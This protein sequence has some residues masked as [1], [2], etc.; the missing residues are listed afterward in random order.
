ME[1]TD[2]GQDAVSSFHSQQ[3]LIM[4][5]RDTRSKTPTPSMDR[6]VA[7]GSKSVENV[8]HTHTL[9]ASAEH[10]GKGPSPSQLLQRIVLAPEDV[11]DHNPTHPT[12]RLAPQSHGLK[13]HGRHLPSGN[14]VWN[15]VQE[16]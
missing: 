11:T 1:E 8:G 2:K 4:A 5:F 13:G 12:I 10:V 9:R 16:V 15:L 7:F 6:I 14:E 3:S